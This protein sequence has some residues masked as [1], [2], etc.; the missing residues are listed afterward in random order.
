MEGG[1]GIWVCPLLAEGPPPSVLVPL[2]PLISFSSFPFLAP[3]RERWNRKEKKKASPAVHPLLL[4]LAGGIRHPDRAVRRPYKHRL[5]RVTLVAA[6]Q[7]HMR[8]IVDAQVLLFLL[9]LFCLTN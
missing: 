5:H 1:G 3:R 6:K 7:E 2:S 9:V 4:F 8:R